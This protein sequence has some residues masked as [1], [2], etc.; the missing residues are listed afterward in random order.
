MNVVTGYDTVT[1]REPLGVFAGIVPWNFPA[2]IPMGWM[3]PLAVTTGNTFVLKADSYV[4]QTAMR[5]AELLEEAGYRLV[6][7]T[8][9]RALGTRPSGFWRI[10]R[11]RA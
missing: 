3:M 1:F 9:S 2:M 10:P 6:C 11:S 4:P 7:S 5:M 8:S